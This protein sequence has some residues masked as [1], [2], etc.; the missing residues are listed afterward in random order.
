MKK[1]IAIRLLFLISAAF[2]GLMGLAF[3]FAAEA[4]FEKFHV[5]PPNH[6]GYIHF[7]AALLIIYALMFLAVAWNPAKNRGLI[8]YGILLKISY[9]AIVF[10]HWFTA[11]IPGMWKP[12]AFVDLVFAALFFWVYIASKPTESSMK[13][14]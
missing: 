1:T 8:P 12:F 9:S 11:D 6:Y 10:Y 7:P 14:V 13:V 5:P 4:V 2:D 3:L